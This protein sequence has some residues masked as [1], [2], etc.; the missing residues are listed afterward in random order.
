M[1]HSESC[2]TLGAHVALFASDAAAAARE[3]K[4]ILDEHDDELTKL[5][6]PLLQLTT[7][8]QQALGALEI[9]SGTARA[10]EINDA[11][12]RALLPHEPPF[13]MALTA[14]SSHD[15]PALPV[16]DA[17]KATSYASAAMV[18]AHLVRDWSALGARPRARVHRPVLAAVRAL[19]RKLHR[20]LSILVPGAGAC[21]LAWE[22]A[23]LG[24]RVEANDASAAMLIAA[25]SLLH[26]PSRLA[27]YPRV[28]CASG[29]VRRSSCLHANLIPDV[30]NSACQAPSSASCTVRGRGGALTLQVSSWEEPRAPPP[31]Y[32][33]MQGV[34]A[35]FDVVVTCYFLDTQS[36]P[37]AAV[38]RVRSLLAPG[39][40]WINVGPLLWH[41]PIAGL[42]RLTLDEL[43]ALLASVG[44]ELRRLRQLRRVPYVDGGMQRLGQ[45]HGRRMRWRSKHLTRNWGDFLGM[46]DDVHDVVYWE[47]VSVAGH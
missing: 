45:P 47:A 9:A 6:A 1:P 42:L 38:E 15:R 28:R 8:Q 43:L 44:F 26:A 41:E 23:H 36:N 3:V 19:Q 11:T 31:P 39:G 18:V 32:A 34:N 22:L 24:N 5:L 2:L 10:W 4:R 27:L 21:R 14:S 7:A 25:H 17:S 13:V 37:A 20:P 46:G 29:A 33:S 40:T 35:T 12:L 16:P 30:I